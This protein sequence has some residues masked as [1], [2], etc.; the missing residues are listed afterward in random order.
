MSQMM[1]NE[2]HESIISS[3]TFSN[4]EE[5][6]QF[7]TSVNA[8]DECARVED[9]SGDNMCDLPRRV[10]S[11]SP[12]RDHKSPVL[13]TAVTIER[14][15]LRARVCISP[16]A[17]TFATAHSRRRSRGGAVV[18]LLASRP[19][20]PGSILGAVPPGLSHVGIVPDDASGKQAF[21]RFFR[22][23]CSCFPALLRIHHV[24]PSS[25]LKT[26][27]LRATQIYSLDHWNSAYIA[28]K[29]LEFS[30]I[31]SEQA[32][33]QRSSV[34]SE[35]STS[36]RLKSRFPLCLVPGKPSGRNPSTSSPK[37]HPSTS[38]DSGRMRGSFDVRLLIYM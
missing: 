4:G 7:I 24:S 21:S 25:A 37:T 20:E 30:H 38:E 18:R 23:A 8:H 16:D 34:L 33:P 9:D 26:L 32:S 15:Y 36:E 28:I 17:R 6:P 19:R 22:F 13:G 1:V 29:A 14:C 2:E 11:R 27:T 5:W 35:H 10:K 3:E 31:K 12:A